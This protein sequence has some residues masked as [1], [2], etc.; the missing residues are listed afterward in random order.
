M[1]FWG[2]MLVPKR[3][4][5]AT[6]NILLMEEMLHSLGCKKN[7]VNNGINYQPQL[8]HG[9]F[10][11][12]VMCSLIIWRLVSTRKP[13]QQCSS[14]WNKCHVRFRM[15]YELIDLSMSFECFEYRPRLNVGKYSIHG[16]YEHMGYIGMFIIVHIHINPQT[17]PVGYYMS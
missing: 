5:L 16:A 6:C 9:F 4:T 15:W 10:P 8:L 11:S 13:P 12:T 1:P 3:V 14:I 7:V 17:L 2:D